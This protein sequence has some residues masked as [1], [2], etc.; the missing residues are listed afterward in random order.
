MIVSRCK[1]FFSKIKR[2]PFLSSQLILTFHINTDCFYFF[3]DRRTIRSI[4]FIMFGHFISK[5]SQPGGE[6]TCF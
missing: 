4:E 1:Y 2:T 5:S 6:E 3:V